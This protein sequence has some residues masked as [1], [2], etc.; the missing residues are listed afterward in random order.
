MVVKL[1]REIFKII[2]ASLILIAKFFAYSSKKLNHHGKK[3]CRTTHHHVAK[4]PHQR[5]MNRD[6]H[7]AKW[8]NWQHH[9]KIHHATLWIYIF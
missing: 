4:R 2:G 1:I 6:G 8:H 9:S 7:Y 5:L 3:L